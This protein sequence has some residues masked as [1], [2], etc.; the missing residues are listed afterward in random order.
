VETICEFRVAN[1]RPEFWRPDS[2]RLEQAAIF[3]TNN[4]VTRLPLRLDPGGSVFVIF[5]PVVSDAPVPVVAIRRNNEPLVDCRSS[6]IFESPENRISEKGSAS[7]DPNDSNFTMA[8]WAKPEVDIPLPP[9]SNFGQASYMMERNDALFPPPGH[10]VYKSPNH[11]GVG[12][13]IGRN[14]VCVFEHAPFYFPPTLVAAVQITNWAH[15]AVVYQRGKPT[16]YLNGRFAHAGVQGDYIVHSGVGVQHRRGMAPFR[17][18]LGEFHS[19]PRALSESE[20]VQLMNRMPI[21]KPASELPS[22]EL[23]Q[24]R[25][26][27]LE[28]QV[29]QEG[30]YALEADEGQRHRFQALELPPPVEI[31]GPWTLSFPPGLGAPASVELESLRSWSEHPNAGVRH[32]SG[33]AAYLTA[34]TADH[35]LLAPRRRVYLDL[36]KVN[37]MAR[38]TLNG[39]NLGVL[40][41]PPFRVEVTQCLKLGENM[42]RVEVVNLWV[43]RMIGDEG[44]APDSVRKPDG[45]LSEWPTWLNSSEKSPSGRQTFSTWP[46]W[47]SSEPLR[48]SGLLGPVQLLSAQ[49]VVLPR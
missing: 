14:G 25:G 12:I 48:E 23:V 22:L 8:V 27:Q 5:R 6:A 2:G 38:V 16:L 37:V 21:P 26:N 47:K 45:T 39:V 7:A 24:T 15:L 49:T 4:G 10:E 18:K 3:S 32:F 34:F 9:Q 13:S 28:A 46:L 20:V 19:E 11:A 44:L 41:K 17:G 36:G 30:D 42:L 33:Q 31:A 40:W 29:W 1:A 43:N 35:N